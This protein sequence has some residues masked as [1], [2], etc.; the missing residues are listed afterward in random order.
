MQLERGRWPRASQ[1]WLDKGSTHDHDDYE[2]SGDGGS[3]MAAL[4]RIRWTNEIIRK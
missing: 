3:E 2:N 4:I 1:R